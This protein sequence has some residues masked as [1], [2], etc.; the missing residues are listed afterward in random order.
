MLEMTGRRFPP[1][2]HFVEHAEFFSVHDGNGQTVGW[3]Y[4][5][6][7]P[8]AARHAGVLEREEARQMA[9]NFARMPELLWRADSGHTARR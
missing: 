6:D 3:F 7:N 2:W 1:R 4:F 5:H 8:E 9:V